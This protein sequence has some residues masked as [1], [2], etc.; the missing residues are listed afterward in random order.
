MYSMQR[1]R[2]TGRTHDMLMTL[3]RSSM[4]TEEHIDNI[5][6]MFI[7]C[8]LHVCMMRDI[9]HSD[10]YIPLISNNVLLICFRITG[11]SIE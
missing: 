6:R 2:R 9:L 4:D 11:G 10:M 5:L 1:R 7:C 3:S 8:L